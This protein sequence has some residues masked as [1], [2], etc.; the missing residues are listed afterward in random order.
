M[1]VSLSHT[2]W[3]VGYKTS[4]SLCGLGPAVRDG[5]AVRDEGMVSSHAAAAATESRE[6]PRKAK[7]S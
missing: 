5:A 4:R 6:D 2:D 3:S 7:G 1:V